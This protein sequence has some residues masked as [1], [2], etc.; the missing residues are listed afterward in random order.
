MYFLSKVLHETEIEKAG[1]CGKMINVLHSLLLLDRLQILNYFIANWKIRRVKVTVWPIPV[2]GFYKFLFQSPKHA[3]KQLLRGGPK[4][5]DS[6]RTGGSGVL[7]FKQTRRRKLYEQVLKIHTSRVSKPPCFRQKSITDE[8]EFI[9]RFTV[10]KERHLHNPPPSLQKWCLL[11][12]V[13]C[14]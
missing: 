10:K 9:G 8:R 3:L 11:S 6:P 7:N 4:T 12:I 5:G 13:D 1:R 14:R 2:S